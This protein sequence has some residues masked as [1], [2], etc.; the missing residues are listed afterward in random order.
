MI[1]KENIEDIYPLS[2]VQ[3]GML[4][5]ALLDSDSQTYFEQSVYRVHGH[6]HIQA[7]EDAWNDLIRR[8]ASLRTAFVSQKT[9]QP[10]QI[11]LREFVLRVA[12]TDLC[13]SSVTEQQAFLDTWKDQDRRM[14]FDLSGGGLLRV[15]LFR[16]KDEVYEVVWSFHHIILDGWSAALL[17]AELFRLYGEII[18][19]AN[20]QAEAGAP[21]YSTYIRWLKAQNVADAKAYCL[22]KRFSPV[23]TS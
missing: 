12:F 9:S 6:I 10:L 23:L 11:V 22:R 20:V 5:H 15:A 17:I 8:H 3:S 2:P 1:Q 19:G 13:A 4:Y 7:F 18:D 16:L 21:A 14:G